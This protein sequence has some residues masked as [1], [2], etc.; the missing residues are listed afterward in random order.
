MYLA[1]EESPT[2]LYAKTLSRLGSVD[3]AAVQ[4]GWPTYRSQIDAAR[5][6]AKE[7]L[8]VSRLLYIEGFASLATL[9]DAANRHFG[10]YSE[11]QDGGPGLLVVDYLQ[12][13]AQIQN[14]ADMSGSVPENQLLSLL[15]YDLR[16]LAKELRCTVLAIS[17]QNRSSGYGNSN[18]L[19]SGSGSGGIEYGADVLMS[20]DKDEERKAPLG[21]KG[22]TV[23]V[24]KNRLG[25]AD[26]RLLLDWRGR[27]QEFR[28]T[29]REEEDDAND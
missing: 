16:L 14:R 20:I 22:R 17:R 26:T 18:A 29:N 27:Y 7:R 15:C 5:Q 24:P 9:R 11:E 2:T 10:R 12:C 3:Y 25:E 13:I 8:S 6:V 19:T 1:C 28:E 21:W 23:V 4:F